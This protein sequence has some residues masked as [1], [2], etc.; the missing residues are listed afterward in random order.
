MDERGGVEAKK[1]NTKG[2]RGR[3]GGEGRKEGRKEGRFLTIAPTEGRDGNHEL[4][5]RAR[6]KGGEG[7]MER[8]TILGARGTRGFWTL[9]K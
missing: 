7:G 3:R 6:E 9:V 8:L 2:E 4:G 5:I 1:G